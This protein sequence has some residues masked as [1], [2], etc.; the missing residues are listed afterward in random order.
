MGPIV[1]PRMGVFMSHGS[2]KAR[3]AASVA[4]RTSASRETDLHMG[5]DRKPTVKRA[6][7]LG[8]D[9]AD[10]RR[11]CVGSRARER[12]F[13][14]RMGHREASEARALGSLDTRERVF[15]DERATRGL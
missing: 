12:V 13:L 2:A 9:E 5:A 15:D 7:E 14:V 3:D 10:T 1:S 6:D 11:N 8:V 4:A